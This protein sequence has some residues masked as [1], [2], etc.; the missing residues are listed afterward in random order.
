MDAGAGALPTNTTL[1]E[2]SASSSGRS[3]A[4]AIPIV[5]VRSPQSPF[6]RPAPPRA[7]A[8]SVAERVLMEEARRAARREA[9]ARQKNAVPGRRFF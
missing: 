9:R 8:L 6:A 7:A 4:P 3:E 1:A 5:R 2:S